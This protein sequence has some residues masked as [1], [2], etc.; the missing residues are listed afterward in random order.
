M[1]SCTAFSRSLPAD[2]RPA[3]F[4]LSPPIFNSL[5][6]TKLKEKKAQA[7][8]DR[9]KKQAEEQQAKQQKWAPRQLSHRAAAAS[10]LAVL[11]AEGRNRNGVPCKEQPAC[12]AA[13]HHGLVPGAPGSVR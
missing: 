7:W 5:Q 10:S 12:C 11:A 1:P 9:L 4:A 2:T 3:P 6:E 13:Q 8:K